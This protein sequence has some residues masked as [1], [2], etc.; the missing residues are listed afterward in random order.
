MVFAQRP[1]DPVDAAGQGVLGERDVVGMGVGG[2]QG[3][4]GPND[5]A[6]AQFQRVDAEGGGEL[7]DR[8]LHG[9]GGLGHAVPA[10]RPLGTV[11]V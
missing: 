11:L 7:V 6:A 9:E 4:A 5:V 10:Q 2:Q 8:A 1:V 3:V